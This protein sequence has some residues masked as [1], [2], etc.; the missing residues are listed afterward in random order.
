MTGPR[1]ASTVTAPAEDSRVAVARDV[2]AEV[3]ADTAP[4]EG[5]PYGKWERESAYWVGVLRHTVRQLLEVADEQAA[6]VRQRGEDG[7]AMERWRDAVDRHW[8]DRS[9]GRRVGP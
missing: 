5:H 8:M 9:G 3:L 7:E 1:T 4:S 6:E 2:L